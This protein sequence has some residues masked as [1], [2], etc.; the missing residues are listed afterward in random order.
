M[1][2]HEF[3]VM[4]TMDL[5]DIYG[6]PVN[7]EQIRRDEKNDFHFRIYEIQSFPT[8]IGFDIDLNWREIKSRLS[9]PSHAVNSGIFDQW[10]QTLKANYEIFQKYYSALVSTG[11]SLKFVINQDKYSQI[12]EEQLSIPWLS[13]S[14][15][16]CTPYIEVYDRF[17]I[18]YEKFKPI[19]VLF[20]GLI[21]SIVGNLAYFA[22]DSYEEGSD[23]ETLVKRYER[24]PLNRALCIAKHGYRCSV[25]GINMEKIYGEIG[26]NFIEVHHII[27]IS[28]YVHAKYIDPE[29]DLVPLCPNCHAMIHRKNPPYSIAELKLIMHHSKGEK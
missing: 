14:V 17:I 21:L 6:L 18:H 20:W 26:R 12:A 22:Q 25:C 10:R 13:F 29:K 23:Y 3:Q 16:L 27:P 8:L 2:L 5:T 1:T 19:L 9:S 28:S 4:L 11:N 15:E 7:V 24:N